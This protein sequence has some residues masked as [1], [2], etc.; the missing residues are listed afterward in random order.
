MTRPLGLSEALALA[1]R[2]RGQN[3]GSGAP[4]PGYHLSVFW[5]LLSLPASIV[6]IGTKA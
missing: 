1:A 2:V 5:V 4:E 6:L 3:A